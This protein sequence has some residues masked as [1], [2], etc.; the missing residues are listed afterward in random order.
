[1]NYMGFAQPLRAFLCGV[2]IAYQPIALSASEC[3]HWMEHY[4]AGLSHQQQLCQF[5]QLDSHD[6]A[7]F[8]TLL[9]GDKQK[10]KLALSW[11]FCWIGVPCLYYGDEIGLE[12]ENDPFCRAPFPWAQ[13]A[14]DHDLLAHCQQLAQLRQQHPA[15]RR[16]ALQ[17]LYADDETL[18][19]ARLLHQE[20]LLVAIQRAGRGILSLPRSPLLSCQK[21]QR[22]LGSGELQPHAELQ[23]E[24]EPFSLTL[25]HGIQDSV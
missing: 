10:M 8:L 7:R 1:M 9:K 21:W 14:W 5:N 19:F 12:G 3:A 13:E 6:T 25:F 22:L 16:G 24:L 4:R 23:L 15:L 11:L 18:I 20:R 17:L 2:D